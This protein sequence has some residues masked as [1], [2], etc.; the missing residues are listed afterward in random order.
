M[1]SL[2]KRKLDKLV[3]ELKDEDLPIKSEEFKLGLLYGYYWA[4]IELFFSRK[5]NDEEK[6]DFVK[7]IESLNAGGRE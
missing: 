3:G 1:D 5:P 6:A 2:F 4:F 7:Y